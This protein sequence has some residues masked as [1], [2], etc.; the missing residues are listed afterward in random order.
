M[1]I[2]I[3]LAL[4]TERLRLRAVDDSDVDLIWSASRYAGFNDGMLWDPPKHKDEMIP[5]NKQIIRSW[6]AG[7]DYVFTVELSKDRF[8]IGRVG[9]HVEDNVV[10][11]WN[12][13]FWIHPEYSGNGYATEAAKVVLEF[14]VNYLAAEV[15]VASHVSWNLQSRRVLEK[16]GF[17]FVRENAAGFSKNGVS[18]AES[19]YELRK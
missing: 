8:P 2:P 10:S 14:G 7:T 15:I 12:I 9:I 3:D 17:A 6:E 11:R 19:E 1:A 13:G 16:L 18:C 5:V 4:E